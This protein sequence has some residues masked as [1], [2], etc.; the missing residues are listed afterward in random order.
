M[1]KDAVP[2]PD[3]IRLQHLG[4]IKDVERTAK[5]LESAVDAIVDVRETEVNARLNY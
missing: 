5:R 2:V 1:S 3:A 4:N